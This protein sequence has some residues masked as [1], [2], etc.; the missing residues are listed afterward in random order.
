M[1]NNMTD[2]LW[3][4]NF[5]TY[6]SIIVVFY[7]IL[8]LV[9]GL[10][11]KNKIKV[12]DDFIVAG[13]NIGSGLGI[14]SM[15]GT[16]MGLI[17]IM[18]SAQKG[19]VG[20]FA[21][22][23]IALIAFFVTLLIGISGFIVVPLRKT[24][25]M[26]I[27]E[28]YE[29]RFGKNVRIIGAIILA[30]GGILNMGLFLKIGSM[31]I[32][33]IMG[34][35]QTGWVLPSIMTSLLIL[36]LV[37]TTLGGMFSVIITDYLQ[38]VILSIVLLFTTYFSIQELGWNNIWNS[39]YSNM[40]E[41]GFNPF[42]EG[43]FGVEYI[44]WMI[45]TAGLVSCA[46]WPT[47]IARALAMKT[48]KDVKIQYKWASISFLVRFLI[49][50]FWG[51]CAFVY[52]VNS[53]EMGSLFF[54]KDESTILNNL[55]ALPIFLGK[56]IPAGFIGVLTAGMIAA[57]MS[58]HDS[59]LLCWSSVI[60]QDIIAPLKKNNL[61]DHRRIQWTR[62]IIIIIGIYILYWGLIYN[63]TE[64]IWDYMAITGSIYFT[65]AISVLIGGLYWEKASST[66]AIFALFGGL[67]SVL[68]LGPVQDFFGISVS[69]TRIG[70]LSICLSIFLLY[71]G[72][73]IFP[74]NSKNKENDE[75]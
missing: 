25:V 74:D 64:D 60:T 63:G 18:Y 37:Y 42:V 36:A 11:A 3:K 62:I 58:T 44:V 72:S 15:A 71:F 16:E 28:Y 47:A 8:T 45:I 14:A 52:F 51:I 29:L 38:F 46:I 17:T 66:G 12:I 7:L 31:F 55:Y 67:F 48:A 5:T 39:V 6:D 70:L 69:G 73:I 22:F 23:H 9:I 4:T 26:T 33:G 34:L 53:A 54:A 41:K 75:Y 35:T 21:A 56:I 65:G 20:G 57:F 2:Y 13:R 50:Y 1:I 19:F 10:Y 43:E 68:G 59:Y 27:P 49:P 30:L 24:N 61:S 40:G 32:V